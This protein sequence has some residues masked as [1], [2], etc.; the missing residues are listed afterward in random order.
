MYVR[1]KMRWPKVEILVTTRKE[2]ETRHTWGTRKGVVI[3]AVVTAQ[4]DSL[5][6]SDKILEVGW[7]TPV[8]Y[9][10]AGL[11]VACQILMSKKTNKADKNVTLT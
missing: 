4:I 9:Y 10:F 5:P 7:I 3:V 1:E 2:K 11:W 6:D 8:Q